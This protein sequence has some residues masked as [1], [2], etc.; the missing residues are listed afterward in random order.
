[1]K[2]TKSSSYILI[3]LVALLTFVSG[4]YNF[5]RTTILSPIAFSNPALYFFFTLYCLWINQYDL[6]D[7]SLLW[8][9]LLL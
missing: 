9:K 2:N 7:G 1:M 6:S 3:L 8:N 4:A 5:Y